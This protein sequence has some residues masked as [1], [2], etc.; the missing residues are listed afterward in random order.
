MYE[1]LNKIFINKYEYLTKIPTY[2]K[3]SQNSYIEKNEKQ[4]VI[5]KD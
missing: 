1:L 3:K 4:Y 5:C 2:N